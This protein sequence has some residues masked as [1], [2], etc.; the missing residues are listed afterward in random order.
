MRCDCTAGRN[1]PRIR[2]IAQ[3]PNDPE[4]SLFSLEVTTIAQHCPI[5]SIE[6]RPLSPMSDHTCRRTVGARWAMLFIPTFYDPY[7]IHL[8]VLSS[9]QRYGEIRTTGIVRSRPCLPN[10]L[11]G[12]TGHLLPPYHPGLVS[13]TSGRLE[14]GEWVGMP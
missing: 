11:L 4:L 7:S 14:M 13:A 3:I 10:F 12:I 2:R 5:R 8:T 1:Y 6:Y 9:D